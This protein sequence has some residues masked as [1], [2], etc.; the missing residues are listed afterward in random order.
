MATARVSD[1]SLSSGGTVVSSSTNK[2]DLATETLKRHPVPLG[3]LNPSSG[4][5]IMALSA[6]SGFIAHHSTQIQLPPP[7]HHHNQ[8][9]LENPDQHDALRIHHQQQPQ[10]RQ[11][12][13]LLS[14][15]HPHHLLQLPL[16]Q[17]QSPHALNNQN[18]HLTSH[19]PH[20]HPASHHHTS[21]VHVNPTH[22]ASPPMPSPINPSSLIHTLPSAP[23][24]TAA[25]ITSP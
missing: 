1:L 12:R 15:H 23:I 22:L 4:A 9:Q 19:N 7:A 8:Q 10:L 2:D 5:S 17:S 6:T 11:Q 14:R 21:A 25:G 13:N 18:P 20:V 24:A 3:Q 16:S